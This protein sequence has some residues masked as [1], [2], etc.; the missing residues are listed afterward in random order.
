MASVTTTWTGS[1]GNGPGSNPGNW[2]APPS[3]LLFANR[4]RARFLHHFKVGKVSRLGN[5]WRPRCL[6]FADRPSMP[7]TKRSSS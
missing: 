2:S 6:A 7:A 3:G 4:L 1:P 5:P